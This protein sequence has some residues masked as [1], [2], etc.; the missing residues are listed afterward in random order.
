MSE[1][2]EEKRCIHGMIEGTCAH[3]MGYVTG[4][5]SP[6]APRTNDHIRLGSFMRYNSFGSCDPILNEIEWTN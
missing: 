3:C 6:R 2:N 4:E 1:L 5:E